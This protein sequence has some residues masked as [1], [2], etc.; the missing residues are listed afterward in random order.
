[1]KSEEIGDLIQQELRKIFPQT[2]EDGI[3]EIFKDTELIAEPEVLEVSGNGIVEF[4][5]ID[6][7]VTI[8]LPHQKMLPATSSASPMVL[9][10]PYVFDL[11]AGKS[12]K[13]RA[14]DEDTI[15]AYYVSREVFGGYTEGV[16]RPPVII[17]K[18]VLT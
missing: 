13:F 4:R 14:V 15:V 5:A 6:V 9:P 16:S 11:E 18:K 12:K 17:I 10:D 2:T 8:F 1:M 7:D 3:I